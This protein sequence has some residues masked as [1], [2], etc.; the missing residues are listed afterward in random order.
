MNSAITGA[1][2]RERLAGFPTYG[3][4]SP[5]LDRL[6]GGG[7]R[8]GRVVEVYGRSGCGKTQLAMQAVLQVA[9]TGESAA[10]IDTE[11]AF[12]PE[13]VLAMAQARKITPSGLLERIIYLRATTAAAQQESVRA[14][15]N[16]AKTRSAK[17]VVIDTI[18]RNFTLDFPGRTNVQSRQGALDVHLSE[19]ARDA[20]LHGRAY[21]LT[22]RITYSQD[23]GE[24]RIGG[25]TV[26]QLVHSSLHLEKGEEGV[27]A[28]RICD[29]LVARIGRITDAGLSQ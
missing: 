25:R 29:G 7:F 16:G 19:I 21:L 5:G 1:E 11:G 14:L 9:A 3:T 20:F 23:G 24:A 28:T 8:A 4:G 26:E 13:R 22:N 2:A 12:R 27:K 18:T 6:L 17:L 15:P 10:F